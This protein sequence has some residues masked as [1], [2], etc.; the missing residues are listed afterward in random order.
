MHK[1]N[2]SPNQCLAEGP[3]ANRQSIALLGCLPSCHSPSLS[4]FSLP[5]HFVW[6]FLQLGIS[7]V[8]LFSK[9]FEGSLG[10]KHP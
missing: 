10:E 8:C 5:D 2:W 1:K 9:F 3:A 6:C 7:F 4:F